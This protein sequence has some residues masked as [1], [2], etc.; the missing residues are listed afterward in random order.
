MAPSSHNLHLSVTLRASTHVSNRWKESEFEILIYA[1]DQYRESML[2]LVNRNR[3]DADEQESE[4][5][6]CLETVKKI[7]EMTTD[8][9]L[10]LCRANQ[11]TE[12]K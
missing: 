11:E 3:D 9:A 2:D 12:Q 4:Y 5:R 8:L 10:S 6:D 7:N 1:L